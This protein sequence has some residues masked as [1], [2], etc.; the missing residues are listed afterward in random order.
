MEDLDY[1]VIYDAVIFKIDYILDF[2]LAILTTVV[3]FRTPDSPKMLFGQYARR[4]KYHGD[5]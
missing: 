5:L 1:L 4:G 2:S 3:K